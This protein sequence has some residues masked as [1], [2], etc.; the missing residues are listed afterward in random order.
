MGKKGVGSDSFIF[1]TNDGTINSA[2]AT[3][4]LS[5]GVVVVPPVYSPPAAGPGGGGGGW[6]VTP[7]PTVT[8]TT[9]I[10][11][12]TIPKPDN[13]TPVKTP[14]TDVPA[15][16]DL[17]S[18]PENKPFEFVL[19]DPSGLLSQLLLANRILWATGWIIPITQKTEAE[20]IVSETFGSI[21][22]SILEDFEGPFVLRNLLQ[23]FVL[24]A[25][26]ATDTVDVYDTA[27]NS[28]ETWQFTPDSRLEKTQKYILRILERNRKHYEQ[29]VYRDMFDG[30]NSEL[31]S[32]TEAIT[33]TPNLN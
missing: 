4:T 25:D 18:A 22:D 30:F 5:V 21:V 12:T 24:R 33:N 15:E 14:T 13:K 10:P 29:V 26:Q 8:S 27:I 11:T 28:V 1:M 2:P 7:N 16:E 23:I 6:S 20:K 31:D 9:T 32:A 19:Y 17:H 3:V